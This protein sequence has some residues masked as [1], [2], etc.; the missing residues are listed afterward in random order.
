MSVF[1][2]VFLALLTYRV[3]EWIIV[4]GVKTLKDSFLIKKKT[5]PSA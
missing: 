4:A 3:T 1:L 5:P 2:S